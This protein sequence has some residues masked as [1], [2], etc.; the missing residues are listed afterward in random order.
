MEIERR[1]VI[2]AA[3]ML[4]ALGID[5]RAVAAEAPASPWAGSIA[6]DGDTIKV[7]KVSID[8]AGKSQAAE[9]DLPADHSPYPL[10][11]QFLTH[12]A[13]KVAIYRAPP[14]LAIAE[15]QPA[16]DLL[17]IVDGDTTLMTDTG[18][19]KVGLGGFVLFD[20][21]AKHTE[22]AGPAGYVA[23]KIRLAD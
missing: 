13:S 2:A 4:A 15:N 1:T 18:S 23:I 10:F 16:K 12:E 7:V 22:T 17:L 21:I 8:A 11:K 6:P 3:G 5:G 20:G 19:R 14:N 9:A